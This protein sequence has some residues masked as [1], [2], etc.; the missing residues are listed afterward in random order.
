[1]PASSTKLSWPRNFERLQE[2][3]LV[4]SKSARQDLEDALCVLSSNISGPLPPP[5][6]KPNRSVSRP[7]PARR[8]SRR[9]VA[10][11]GDGLLAEA[12]VGHD[13]SLDGVTVVPAAARAVAAGTSRTV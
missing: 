3:S 10:L 13:G 7:D 9:F 1:M 4:S 6:L 11:A 5:L 2:E 8:G 12:E